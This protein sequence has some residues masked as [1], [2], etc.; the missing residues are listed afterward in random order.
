[1]V[2]WNLSYFKQLYDQYTA[3]G[4]SVRVFCQSQGIKE[5]RFYYWIH[6]LKLHAVPVV[7]DS[8]A[9]IPL[10]SQRIGCLTGVTL[11][12]K[13]NRELPESRQSITLTYPNGVV[14]ELGAGCDIEKLKQLVTLIS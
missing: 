4:A 10:T 6:K 11:K 2:Y 12:E 3:S 13:E 1:M 14:L 7:K 5:N 9:F 8:K